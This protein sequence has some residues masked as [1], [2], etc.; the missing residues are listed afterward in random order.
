MKL[1]KIYEEAEYYLHNSGD[2]DKAAGEDDSFD[3]VLKG[4][5]DQIFDCFTR[6]YGEGYIEEQVVE[7]LMEWRDQG[8]DK[9]MD[10]FMEELWAGLLDKV[11]FQNSIEWYLNEEVSDELYEHYLLRKQEVNN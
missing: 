10:D 11:K 2:L 4:I 3:A 6:D 7:T 1:W 8:Y 5:Q 9:V